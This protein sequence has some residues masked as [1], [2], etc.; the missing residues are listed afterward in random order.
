MFCIV[1]RSP[2]MRSKTPDPNPSFCIAAPL[3]WG[4]VYDLQDTFQSQDINKGTWN[5]MS[6]ARA[7]SMLTWALWCDYSRYK[8]EEAVERHTLYTRQYYIAPILHVKLWIIIFLVFFYFLCLS[9]MALYT[10]ICNFCMREHSRY[11]LFCLKRKHHIFNR[12][13]SKTTAKPV[14]FYTEPSGCISKNWK[15]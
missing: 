5:V 13:L 1:K 8:R 10:V 14:T 9:M 7:L 6:P 11:A 15:Y 3:K 4:H 12:F 2:S